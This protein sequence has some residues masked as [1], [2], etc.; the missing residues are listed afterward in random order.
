MTAYSNVTKQQGTKPYMAPEMFR[1]DH[2]NPEH[3]SDAY[4]KKSDMHSFGIGCAE[5][6]FRNRDV[7]L[8]LLLVDALYFCM[9]TMCTIGYG[10]IVPQTSFAKLF[11]CL[12][13][14]IGF[15][16]IGALVSGMVTYV[17]D[18]QEHLGPSAVEGSHFQTAKKHF[19]NAKHGNQMR[20][21]AWRSS[22]LSCVFSSAPRR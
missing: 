1:A 12:L 4:P 7:L 22:C 5:I 21:W 9:I 6:V 3:S 14:L 2:Y 15:G 10:D 16:F 19:L 13:V 8:L 11:S 17:L 20:M 18:E